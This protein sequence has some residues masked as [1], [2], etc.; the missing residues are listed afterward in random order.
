M[1]TV[2]LLGASV[3]AAL[4]LSA[5]VAFSNTAKT[6]AN[7][8]TADPIVGFWNFS[9]GV[10]HVT[11]SGAG[12]K[13]IVARTTAFRGSPCVHPAGE[14]IW[15]ITKSGTRYK[16]TH[17]YFDESCVPGS[18]GAGSSS[19]S[20]SHYKDRF[21]LHF[22]STVPGGTARKCADLTR[23]KPVEPVTLPTPPTPPAEGK[24]PPKVTAFTTEGFARPGGKVDMHFSVWDNSGRARVHIAVYQGGTKLDEGWSPWL[25]AKGKK[26]SWPGTVDAN[27]TGPLYFC[28]FGSDA[29]GNRGKSSC[30]WM[31]LRVPI[32]R[33]SNGCGGEGWDAVVGVENYFGNTHTY[34]DSNVNPLAASYPVSFVNSC[35]LH[36]AGY[37][38]YAV[39]DE[40]NHVIVDF[41]SWTRPRVDRKFLANMRK[42]CAEQIPPSATT[43]LANCQ[44]GGGNASIGAEWLYA[45]VAKIGWRF[46][47]TNLTMPGLQK[48]GPRYNFD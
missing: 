4:C 17:Q 30:A 34:V 7:A 13:G 6:S 37:G 40:I 21:V 38:G 1:R 14:T 19:W 47:D 44:A 48:I 23:A 10:I 26:V 35:N 5:G 46:F 9:G 18:G 39:W 43:A 27:S 15:R 42:E 28:V 24:L 20:I 12:F 32:W 16:G 25:S 22:C 31:P 29:A 2:G 41:R 45:L 36:D 11:K 33:V 8:A 3:L